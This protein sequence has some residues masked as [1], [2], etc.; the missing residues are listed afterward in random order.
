MQST[1]LISLSKTFFQETKLQKI[2]QFVLEDLK[3]WI[4]LHFNGDLLLCQ[5][6]LLQK[7]E[8]D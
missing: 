5:K 8:D 2:V 4:G 7:V 1:E 6:S 3:D